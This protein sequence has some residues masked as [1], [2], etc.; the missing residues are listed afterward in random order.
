MIK[1]LSCPKSGAAMA[2]PAVRTVS[3]GPAS[4]HVLLHISII[5]F[6]TCTAFAC[7]AITCTSL[8]LCQFSETFNSFSG[9]L[10]RHVVLTYQAKDALT[11]RVT[12][13]SS[14]Q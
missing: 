4:T 2:V 12:Y 13:C 8:S 7:A 11:L 3:D 1:A 6:A 10:V 5:N 9:K 14:P